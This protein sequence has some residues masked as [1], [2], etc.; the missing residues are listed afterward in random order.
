MTAGRHFR[1]NVILKS[2]RRGGEF[3]CTAPIFAT[4]RVKLFRSDASEHSVTRVEGGSR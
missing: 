1:L 4:R 2:P 3:V